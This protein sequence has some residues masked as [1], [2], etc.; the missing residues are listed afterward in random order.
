MTGPEDYRC[1]HC[2]N[3]VLYRIDHK[4][5]CRHHPSH[6]KPVSLN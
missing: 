2:G 6:D 4:D 3:L 1:Q 5:E